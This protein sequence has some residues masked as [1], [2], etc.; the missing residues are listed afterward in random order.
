MERVKFTRARK[1]TAERSGGSP[2]GA[3]P[4]TW[5][6]RAA[7]PVGGDLG[8]VSSGLWPRLPPVCP[9]PGPALPN[10]HLS[11]DVAGLPRVKAEAPAVS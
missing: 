2:G 1:Y 6:P 8:M 7:W 10:E 5:W 9:Q 3:Q 11:V 4:S